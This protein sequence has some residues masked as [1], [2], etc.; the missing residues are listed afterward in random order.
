MRLRAPIKRGLDWLRVDLLARL[1]PRGLIAG[2]AGAA[3]G[4]RRRGADRRRPVSAAT[5][6]PR[7][8]PGWSPSRS[9]PTIPR[10]RRSG[11]WASPWSRP[12]TP[13]GS[14]APT[15]PPMPPPPRSP[16]IPRPRRQA[17]RGRGPGR[18]RRLAGR[19]RRRGAGRAAA[20]GPA[21][22]RRSRRRPR[23][24]PHRPSPSSTHAAAAGTGDVAV[25]LV[26]GASAPSELQ[27][28]GAARGPPRRRSPTRSTSCAQRLIEGEPEHIV[29]ASSDKPA[30][31]MPAAAWAA[32]S[33]DPVLF[34][35]ARRGARGDP[36]R[37]RRHRGVPVYVLGPES[38]ISEEALREIGAGLARR[39]AGRRG[40]PG[41]QRDR[42]RPLHGLLLRLEHQRPRARAGARQHLAAARRRRRGDAL[43]ERQVGPAPDH[44]HA[45][46]LCPPS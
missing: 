1:E 7:P 17:D 19:D 39:P 13:P 8:R 22:D 40:G 3:R 28:G 27:V 29:I 9:R 21:A 2:G 42:L 46:T 36:R 31:A 4:D 5:A 20:A 11:P 43:G 33:G 16:P 45:R 35:G 18:R 26:G 38:V 15:R 6:R 23:C 24:R 37:A 34:S 32:R 25:Y 44:R 10:R 14:A 12:A 30:Y 41:R